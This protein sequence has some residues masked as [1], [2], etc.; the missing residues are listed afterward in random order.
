MGGEGA[1]G[2]SGEAWQ[3]SYYL[4]L[5]EDNGKTSQEEDQHV[6]SMQVLA[7]RGRQWASDT[8]GASVV[9]WRFGK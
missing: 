1:G 5:K 4:S 8:G 2:V 9:G 3:G 7:P 6:D